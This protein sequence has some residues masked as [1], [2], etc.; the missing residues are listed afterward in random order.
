MIINIHTEIPVSLG[1][2]NRSIIADQTKPALLQLNLE[3][4]NRRHLNLNFGIGYCDANDLSSSSRNSR[5]SLA[6]FIKFT[7]RYY[8]F[9][10]CLQKKIRDIIRKYA[11]TIFLAHY[12]DLYRVHIYVFVHVCMYVCMYACMY[13]CMHVCMYVCRSV[14]MYVRVY[15]YICMFYTIFQTLGRVGRP[16]SMT[17]SLTLS[18]AI[19]SEKYGT[20]AYLNKI[21]KMRFLR[22]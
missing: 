8:Q 11:N 5:G 9:A 21:S 6:K 17:N 20:S 2:E 18:V 19:P 7:K 14:C 4:T 16:P 3:P 22:K 1:I 15:M 13:V 12:V 10:L